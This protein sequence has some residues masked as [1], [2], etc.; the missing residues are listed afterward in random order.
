M[1]ITSKKFDEI[2]ENKDI[3]DYL[4]FSKAISVKEFKKS[5][6]LQIEFTEPLIFS[7]NQEAKKIGV[8]PENLIKMWVSEKLN[9]K[10][11]FCL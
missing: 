8:A 10:H 9:K 7:L 11:A 5:H 6:T 3:S 4:D 2:F 1:K